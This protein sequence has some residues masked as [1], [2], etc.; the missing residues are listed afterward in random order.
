MLE[1]KKHFDIGG[2]IEIRKVDIEGVACIYCFKY[3]S[4]FNSIKQAKQAG[5]KSSFLFTKYDK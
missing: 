5:K 3:F 1:M 4:F 2:S